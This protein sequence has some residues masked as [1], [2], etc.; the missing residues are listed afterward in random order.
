MIAVRLPGFQSAAIHWQSPDHHN[1]P[2]VRGPARNQWPGSEAILG[3]TCQVGHLPIT[4]PPPSRRARRR[5]AQCSKGGGLERVAKKGYILVYLLTLPD[6][7]VFL[8]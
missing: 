4:H 8:W 7:P 1:L 2:G 5:A 6:F 3:E